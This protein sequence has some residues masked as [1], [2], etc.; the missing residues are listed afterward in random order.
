MLQKLK[1]L[2][3]LNVVEFDLAL[4]QM[5]YEKND[6]GED[7][8]TEE[9]MRRLLINLG[10]NPM[11]GFWIGFANQCCKHYGKAE[12]TYA[13][14]Q[15]AKH[16][17]KPTQAYVTAILE[18]RRTKNEAEATRLKAEQEKKQFEK[19]YNPEVTKNIF[20]EALKTI[21]TKPVENN[22][23]EKRR[24]KKEKWYKDLELGKL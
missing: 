15:T 9:D 3:E 5:G 1:A 10:V 17:N 11:S 24:L 7:I 22:D 13:L 19:E 16:T 20:T 18:R 8:F 14:E 4:K 21:S 6:S 12:A 23:E 2:R